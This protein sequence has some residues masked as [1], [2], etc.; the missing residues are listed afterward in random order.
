MMGR[1]WV[2]GLAPTAI[3]PG[4]VTSVPSVGQAYSMFVTVAKEMQGM[5]KKA[6]QY[7]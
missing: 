6:L 2:E 3:G 1:C 4:V 7:P 5:Q